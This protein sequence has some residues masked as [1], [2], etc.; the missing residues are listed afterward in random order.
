MSLEFMGH[1]DG[2]GPLIGD[3]F[4]YEQATHFRLDPNLDA[5]PEPPSLVLAC[6]GL[7]GLGLGFR[8]R[9][10]RAA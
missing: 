3:A 8:R 10:R 1:F 2:E 7:A 5:V 4:A 6:A 9:L